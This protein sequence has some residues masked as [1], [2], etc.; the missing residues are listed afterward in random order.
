[1]DAVERGSGGLLIK[2]GAAARAA[3]QAAT[4]GDPEFQSAVAL[5]PDDVIKSPQLMKM[6]KDKP[7]LIDGIRDEKIRAQV[8]KALGREPAGA[9][10]KIKHGTIKDGRIFYGGDPDDQKNWKLLRKGQGGK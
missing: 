4:A 9:P 7:E 10:K 1:V 6:F 3:A 8:Q 2:G 5:S